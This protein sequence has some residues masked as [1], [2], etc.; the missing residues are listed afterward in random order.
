MLRDCVLLC[1]W[2]HYVVGSVTWLLP[3]CDYVPLRGCVLFILLRGCV[4]LRGHVLFVLLRGCILLHGCVLLYGYI[5]YV[6]MSHYVV[7]SC[8]VV[9]SRYVVTSHYLVMSHYLVTSH[10][11]LL[12]HVVTTHFSL[13]LVVM[14]FSTNTAKNKASLQ[15]CRC[16]DVDP[17]IVSH[18]YRFRLLSVLTFGHTRRQT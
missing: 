13:Y 3:L 7:V 11:V 4:Q 14:A 6:I 9:A 18:N 1:G 17:Y 15:F 16:R 2:S 10:Y 8:Y 5:R 12:H